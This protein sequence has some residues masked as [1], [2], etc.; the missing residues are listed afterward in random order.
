MVSERSVEI[1]S[2]I[3]T[4]SCSKV[5]VISHANWGW[6]RLIALPTHKASTQNGVDMTAEPCCSYLR[7]NWPLATSFAAK[8]FLVTL[9]LEYWYY[10]F[11]KAM[12]WNT[13]KWGHCWICN[14]WHLAASDCFALLLA[15]NQIMAW[16]TVFM[17]FTA[18]HWRLGKWYLTA[19]CSKK[20]SSC[21]NF[22]PY[23]LHMLYS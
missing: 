8:I 7:Q 11:N 2:M 13:W 6:A 14:A 1:I 9:L 19:D 5:T 20:Q 21:S 3:P 12:M 15:L 23:N 10:C 18:D 4:I 17:R 16:Y 22:V